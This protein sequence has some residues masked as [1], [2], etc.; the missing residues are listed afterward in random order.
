MKSIAAAAAAVIVTVYIGLV[1]QAGGAESRRHHPVPSPA[2]ILHS[3]DDNPAVTPPHSQDKYRVVCTFYTHV[4]TVQGMQG[5]QQRDTEYASA[6]L[7]ETRGSRVKGTNSF[8]SPPNSELKPFILDAGGLGRSRPMIDKIETNWNLGKCELLWEEQNER[9]PYISKRSHI[10]QNGV[11]MSQGSKVKVYLPVTLPQGDLCVRLLQPLSSSSSTND[12]LANV[13]LSYRP[14]E[15]KTGGLK[16]ETKDLKN[17]ARVW[18]TQEGRIVPLY[19]DSLQRR[20]VFSFR[21]TEGTEKAVLVFKMEALTKTEE[22]VLKG[23]EL[24]CCDDMLDHSELPINVGTK[25]TPVTRDPYIGSQESKRVKNNSETDKTYTNPSVHVI[26]KRNVSTTSADNPTSQNVF[27]TSADIPTSQDVSTTS[28]GIST[29]QDVF[30]TSADNPTSQDVFTTS[31]DIKI[32]PADIPVDVFTT[33]TSISTLPL[34]GSTNPSKL[35][36]ANEASI[37]S[38]KDV[39]NPGEILGIVFGVLFSLVVLVGVVVFLYLRW[40]KHRQYHVETS[41]DV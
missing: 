5:R 35:K 17:R 1:S 8:L 34:D 39:H 6:S 26:R 23:V 33:P 40:Q 4:C 11:K 20:S 9:L 19:Q 22:F 24:K 28:G 13:S 41:E 37:S 32:T 16:T 30:T 31:A 7:Y 36:G 14:E 12:G 10:T 29:L 25:S 18:R 21:L 38:S 2:G 3:A 15:E 27:T